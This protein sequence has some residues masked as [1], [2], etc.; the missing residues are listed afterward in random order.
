MV[1]PAAFQTETVFINDW[2]E[3]GNS[4]TVHAAA[5]AQLT[6][7]GVDY[8]D[9]NHVLRTGRVV[10]SDMRESNGLWIV[11]GE[12]VDDDELFLTICVVSSESKVELVAVSMLG[13]RAR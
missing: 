9:I 11:Q 6:A 1:S 2:V 12:T 4:L 7:T 5:D 13:K 3:T 8:C 10:N